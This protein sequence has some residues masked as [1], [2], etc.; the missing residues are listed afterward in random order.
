MTEGVQSRARDPELLEER[1]ELPLHEKVLVPRGAVL[2]SKEQPLM[3]RTPG[4]DESPKVL[5]QVRRASKSPC[6]V[7][8][9]RFLKLPAPRTLSHVHLPG[10]E[11]H[12]FKSQTT[13]F[14][15]TQSRFRGQPVE[16]P[17]RLRCDAEDARHFVLCE[18]ESTRSASLWQHHAIKRVVCHVLPG[19]C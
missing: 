14:S 15:C 16:C 1:A 4:S 11:I 18:K 19:A 10:F 5:N 7:L 13:K 9:F 17:V 2:R 3:I 12:I 8:R 6:G